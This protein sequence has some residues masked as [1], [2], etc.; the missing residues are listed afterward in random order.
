MCCHRLLKVML[1]VVCKT[2]INW[3]EPHL[4]DFIDSTFTIGLRSN[5]CEPLYFK[6]DMND[7]HDKTIQFDNT[8]NDLGLQ[9]HIFMR[10]IELVQ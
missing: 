3:R 10:K 6:L 2:H 9:G 5:A 1:K 7:R 4:G 8:L